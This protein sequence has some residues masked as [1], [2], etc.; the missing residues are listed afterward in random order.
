MLLIRIVGFLLF[1]FSPSNKDEVKHDFHTSLTEMRYNES[2]KSFE[3]TIRVFTDDLESM[4]KANH[5]GASF[6]T[7]NS[8]K[9]IESY[10]KKNFAF[11]KGKEVVFGSFLGKESE[12]DVTWLYFEIDNGEVLR[13][14]FKMLNSIF[15]DFFNDQKNLVN[16][17]YKKERATLIFSD[18]NKLQSF[19]F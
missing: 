7:V 5:K 6:L 8:D 10:V 4:I 17:L 18:D 11:V 19:P 9:I 14:G 1:S 13:D 3:L 12:D 15:F 2:T 16:V